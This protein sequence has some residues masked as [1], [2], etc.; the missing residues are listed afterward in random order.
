MGYFSNGSEGR[1]YQERFCKLCVHDVKEDCRVWLAH[2]MENGNKE[3]R[4]VLDALIPRT[5][6][7]CGN[8]QCTMFLPLAQAGQKRKT[9]GE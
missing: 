8:E 5:A 3:S 1:D 6:D 7:G 9:E 2:L 4:T